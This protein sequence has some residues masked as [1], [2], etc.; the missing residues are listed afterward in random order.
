MVNVCGK[1]KMRK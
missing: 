1:D